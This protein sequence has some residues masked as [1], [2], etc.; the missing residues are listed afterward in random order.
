MN[1]YRAKT[2]TVS[3]Q[4]EV[5]MVTK[6][7][8]M[9]ASCKSPPRSPSFI[10]E[11]CRAPEQR[12]LLSEVPQGQGNKERTTTKLACLFPSLSAS[13]DLGGVG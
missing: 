6:A 7:E 13:T 10:P 8:R 11:L 9:S 4:R 3:L 5:T 1:E 2:T 12:A